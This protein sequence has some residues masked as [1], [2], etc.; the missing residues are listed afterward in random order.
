MHHLESDLH[1]A[2]Y[3]LARGFML[4]GLEQ[5]GSR[6]SFRFDDPT[7]DVANAKQDYRKGSL[8]AARDFAAAIQEL[9]GVLYAEKYK[10]GNGNGNERAN[11]RR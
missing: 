4:L 11:Y 10:G 9:K 3:L 8:I 1:I 5:V 2:A 7:Q 6:Y